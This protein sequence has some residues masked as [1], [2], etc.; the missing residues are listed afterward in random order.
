M[1]NLYTYNLL[2]DEIIRGLIEHYKLQ[3]R[4]RLAEVQP[5]SISPSK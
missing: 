1:G 5:S 2:R 3:R 4:G